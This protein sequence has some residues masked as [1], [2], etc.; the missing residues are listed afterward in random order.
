MLCYYIIIYS[1]LMFISSML[2]FIF[3]FYVVLT[4]ADYVLCMYV[5]IMV[6]PYRSRDD[7]FCKQYLGINRA[8][9]IT[10]LKM[11]HHGFGKSWRACVDF[12]FYSWLYFC[13]WLYIWGWLLTLCL[14]DFLSWLSFIFKVVYYYFRCKIL[15][16]PIHYHTGDNSLTIL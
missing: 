12:I 10:C 15:N 1:C 6:M 16:N 11:M 2:G 8:S 4:F 3:S 7:P 9:Y 13:C 14:F 5:L